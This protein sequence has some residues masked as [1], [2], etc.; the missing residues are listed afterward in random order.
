MLPALNHDTNGT[1][2]TE[3]TGYISTVAIIIP[4]GLLYARN[5]HYECQMKSLHRLFM[6][7]TSF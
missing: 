3:H 5:K 4:N 1:V 2:N 7:L 6:L